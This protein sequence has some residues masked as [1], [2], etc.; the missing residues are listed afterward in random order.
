MSNPNTT[1]I[2]QRAEQSCR[3]TGS[4]LTQKR[5]NVLQS[6]LNTSTPLSAYEVA[7]NYRATFRE[8]IPIMS[9]YRMLDFLMQENLVHKISS[10]KKYIACSHI[11]CDHK[12]ETPQFLICEQCH[13]VR[14]ISVKKSII[15]ALQES[16]SSI[17]FT[18]N[19]PQLDLHGV[20]AE[21][22]STP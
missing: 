4:Q 7:D 8:S 12:H 20:C 21:C 1:Y 3:E 13:N 5:K 6:L 15:E 17:G 9:V 11:A 19:S 2:L 14:E 16:V 10:T 18:L 22:S